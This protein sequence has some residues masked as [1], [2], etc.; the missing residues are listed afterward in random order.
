[1]AGSYPGGAK[2]TGGRQH[3]SST[4]LPAT[5]GM[6][7]QLFVPPAASPIRLPEAPVMTVARS[8]GGTGVLSAMELERRKQEILAKYGVKGT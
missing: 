1:M 4:T 3:A 6:N 5:S 8:G 7:R 2:G